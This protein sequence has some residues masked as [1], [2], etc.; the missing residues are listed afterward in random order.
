MEVQDSYRQA[1]LSQVTSNRFTVYRA[2]R[3]EL[4][5]FRFFL[6]SRK[7]LLPEKW[8]VKAGGEVTR[9]FPK[10]GFAILKGGDRTSLRR[11]E[12]S[13]V[14]PECGIA[15]QCSVDR[16]PARMDPPGT[17]LALARTAR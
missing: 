9:E 1:R 10:S 16:K 15:I 13:D 6:I 3:S 5:S 17:E 8:A 11:V 14:E 4:S 2:C 7:S 12:I